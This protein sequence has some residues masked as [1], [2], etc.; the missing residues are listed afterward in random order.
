MMYNVNVLKDNV[1]IINI[2]YKVKVSSGVDKKCILHTNGCLHS[3]NC[4]IRWHTI[5]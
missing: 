5:K 4:I 2:S 3:H 1:D